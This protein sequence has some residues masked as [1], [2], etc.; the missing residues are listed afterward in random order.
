MGLEAYFN[1]PEP[2]NEV[3]GPHDTRSVVSTNAPD[4]GRMDPRSVGSVSGMSELS[5]FAV[6]TPHIRDAA[7]AE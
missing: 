7:M 5:Q 2:T 6:E 3:I 4:G 1:E